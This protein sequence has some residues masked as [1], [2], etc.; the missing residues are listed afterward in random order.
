MGILMT[1]FLLNHLYWYVNQTRTTKK[2]HEKHTKY[3]MALEKNTKHS[4]NYGK[5]EERNEQLKKFVLFFSC[6]NN[7]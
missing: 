1:R 2:K 5:A 7:T 4:K 6:S 3:Q